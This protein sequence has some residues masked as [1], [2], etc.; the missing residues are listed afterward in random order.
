M[1]LSAG[2]T[3]VSTG[4]DVGVSVETAV[5]VKEAV[6]VSVGGT[7]VKVGVS[8]VVAMEVKVLVGT[9]VLTNVVKLNVALW[10]MTTPTPFMVST[11]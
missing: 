3:V 10:A 11:L 8:V 4:V 6:G 2:G 5:F 1:G 7:G 9:G